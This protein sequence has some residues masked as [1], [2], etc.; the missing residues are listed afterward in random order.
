MQCSSLFPNP[1]FRPPSSLSRSLGLVGNLLS[2]VILLSTKRLKSAFNFML[3]LNFALQSLYILSSLSV[4]L[5]MRSP[6]SE[7]P[8]FHRSGT[9]EGRKEDRISAIWAPKRQ[10]I[11]KGQN[12]SSGRNWE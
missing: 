6:H 2:I 4:E 3:I 11:A 1:P 9:K 10:I 8:L 7:S 12:P 5:Y